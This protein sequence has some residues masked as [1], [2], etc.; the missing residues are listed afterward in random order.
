[1]VAVYSLQNGR[2]QDVAPDGDGAIYRPHNTHA[3]HETEKLT[4]LRVHLVRGCMRALPLPVVPTM[5][6]DDALHG[7]DTVDG[8]PQGGSCAT[9]GTP[10]IIRNQNNQARNIAWT[11]PYASSRRS[12]ISSSTSAKRANARSPRTGKSVPTAGSGWPRT[13]RVAAIRCHLPVRRPAPGVAWQY[14][15]ASP[16]SW[17]QR[18]GVV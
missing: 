3:G 18:P 2:F 6:A 16:E 7:V 5:A 12:F 14:H 13:A 8:S 10:W 9:E 11:P 1:M 17:T 15:R 4:C